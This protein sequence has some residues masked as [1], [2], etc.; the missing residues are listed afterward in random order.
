MLFLATK[1]MHDC[2]CVNATVQKWARLKF[3]GKQMDPVS[4]KFFVRENGTELSVFQLTSPEAAAIQEC[5]ENLIPR[6]FDRSATF[7]FEADMCLM[8]EEDEE[9]AYGRL[10]CY[11]HNPHPANGS[12]DSSR[13]PFAFPTQLLTYLQ[14]K[15]FQ[16]CPQQLGLSPWKAVEIVFETV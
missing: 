14:G 1:R 16:V 11:T 3:K 6:P 5:V 4:L 12:L 2:V 7:W 8:Q 9:P 10:R 13:L 15:T